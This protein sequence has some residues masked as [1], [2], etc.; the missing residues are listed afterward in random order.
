MAQCNYYDEQSEWV[1]AVEA[2]GYELSFWGGC[3]SCDAVSDGSVV[4]CWTAD[5]DCG[6]GVRASGWLTV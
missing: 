2:C 6:N 4:G 5:F 1:A 3:G